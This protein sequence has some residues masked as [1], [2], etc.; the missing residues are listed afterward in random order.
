MPRWWKLKLQMKI[1]SPQKNNTPSICLE[2]VQLYMK[3][4]FGSTVRPIQ[5]LIDFSAIW[6]EPNE[7]KEVIF[8]VDESKSVMWTAAGKF[9]TEPGLFSLYTGYADH[10]LYEQQFRLVK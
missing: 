10:L 3:D 7:E 8:K 4:Q 1:I 9:D 5:E 2:V 6:L